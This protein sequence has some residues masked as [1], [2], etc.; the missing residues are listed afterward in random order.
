MIIDTHVHTGLFISPE[1]T[2]DM[3]EKALTMY[4]R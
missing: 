1:K 4:R 2:V 3:S